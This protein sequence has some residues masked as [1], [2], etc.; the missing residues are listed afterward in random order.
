M[1]SYNSINSFARGRA[2]NQ[3]KVF[4]SCVALCFTPQ[5]NFAQRVISTYAG[6]GVDDGVSAISASTSVSAVA[7]DNSGNLYISD[8]RHNRI[9]KVDA[10]TGIIST[11]AGMGHFG[12]TGDGG[13]ATA[14]RLAAP[15][16]IVVD[17]IGNIYFIEALSHK[18]RL[19]DDTGKI[20]TVAG[21]GTAG[22]AGDGGLAINAS[23]SYP[24]GLLLDAG[25]NLYIGDYGNN[26]VRKIDTNGFISTFAGNGTA[27]FAGDG[28]SATAAKLNGP[29]SI[30]IDKYGNIFISDM[31]NY[32]VRKVDAS[33]IIT[34]VAGNGG[35]GSINTGDGGIALSATLAFFNGIAM[36]A[37][38]NLY[39]CGY[40]SVRRV[41]GSGII[42]TV[43]GD[44]T[45]GDSGDGGIASNAKLFPTAIAID[46]NNDVYVGD[47]ENSKVRKVSFGTSLISTV[48]GNGLA[49]FWGDNGPGIDSW[50]LGPFGVVADPAGNL[51]VA[52]TWNSRVRKIDASSG[53]I[54]TIAGN[55]QGGYYNQFRSDGDGL[56]ATQ[57]L[58]GYPR[59]VAF[60]D[61]GNLYISDGEN[62][63][64]RK[65]DAITGV[66]TTIAGAN[67][68]SPPPYSFG[69]DGGPANNASFNGISGLTYANGNL[70]VADFVNCRVRKIDLFTGIIS[71]VAGDGSFFSAKSVPYPYDVVVDAHGNLYISQPAFNQV[72]KV[73]PSGIVTKIAG[74][75]SAGFSGDGGLA[76]NA[77]LNDPR[78]LC[79]DSFGNLYF[80]DL[81]NNRVRKIDTNGII[82]TLVGNGLPYDIGD[83]GSVINASIYSPSGMTLDNKGNLYVL[84][85][86]HLVR[87]ISRIDPTVLFTSPVSASYGDPLTL[88]SNNGGSTGA[89]VYSVTNGTGTGI[90]SGNV[91]SCTGAGTVTVKANV[92]ADENFNAGTTTQTVTINKA[93]LNVTPNDSRRLYGGSN[94]PFTLIYTG[95]KGSDNPT[96]IDS[97]PIAT[98]AATH[99]SDAGTYAI[100][101]A[102]GND[103]NY[104]F[105]YLNGTLTVDKSP[106]QVKADNKSRVY[107]EANPV[108]T[109]TFSGFVG[110]DNPSVLDSP[111]KINTMATPT[112][113]VGTYVIDVQ[114]GLDN[115]Y[116]FTCSLGSLTVNKADQTIQFNIIEDKTIGDPVFGLTA[117]SSSGLPVNYTANSGKVI[118]SGDQVTIVQTGRVTIAA[119]QVGNNNFSSAAQVSQE[120]CVNPGQPVISIDMTNPTAPVLIS[121]YDGANKWFLNGAWISDPSATTNKLSVQTGSGP[122]NVQAIADG[123]CLSLIS[124]NNVLIVTRVDADPSVGISSYPNPVSTTVT[125][126]VDENSIGEQPVCVAIYDLLGK[127][128]KLGGKEMLNHDIDL[129]KFTKGMYM[130]RVLIGEQTKTIKVIKE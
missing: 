59:D 111:P 96:E 50:L 10:N 24:S 93:I 118:I 45:Q 124:D 123:E 64:I 27:A 122:Y 7:V 12:S 48:A 114:G 11:I 63:R 74:N 51:F 87:K 19:I 58:I 98:T 79:F 99:T 107:G 55:Y 129:S 94:P 127:L 33:G 8:V 34:T 43:I 25:G 126:S 65:V 130:V 73:D 31:N 28:G 46:A 92:E 4:L 88:S 70:Y 67:P 44:G 71:T 86:N 62:N 60:D 77:E 109:L 125:L 80:T 6:A 14:A 68:T 103:N 15:S 76:I 37:L 108:L 20:S 104:S 16:N 75:G 23:L 18:I 29:S 69:G 5:F 1:P 41:E 53:E 91:L 52:D 61:A 78:D 35:D 42:S 97:P 57:A 30:A 82:S 38:D 21:N 22:F 39:I 9:R 100:A 95:F 110:N 128:I 81:G 66:I 56:L 90:L 2:I 89:I 116:S 105:N 85:G 102:G 83:G 36:D 47:F 101:A 117:H 49:G 84:T 121:S 112:S 32:R 119:S 115:N 54:V 106:L 113:D 120:F 40:A 72:V 26:R 13:P 17:P 3:L